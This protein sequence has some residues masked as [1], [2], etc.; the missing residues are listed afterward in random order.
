[1]AVA[2]WSKIRRENHP[3]SLCGRTPEKLSQITEA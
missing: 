2:L 1:M 3:L